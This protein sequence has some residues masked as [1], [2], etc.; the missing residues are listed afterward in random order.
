MREEK[1][2]VEMSEEIENSNESNQW[3]FENYKIKHN[4]LASISKMKSKPRMT[5]TDT[6]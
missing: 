3:N 5:P 2:F 6:Q 4:K 1:N